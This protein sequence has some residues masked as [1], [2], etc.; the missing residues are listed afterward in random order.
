MTRSLNRLTATA[1]AKAKKPGYFADGG[2]LYLQITAIGAKSWV[3]RYERD[4]R[5]R[6]MGLG[7]VRDFSLAE[8]RERAKVARKQLA[9]GID[10]LAARDEERQ[11]RKAAAAGMMTFRAAAEA[12]IADKAA[13]WRNA[14]HAK[15]WAA[16]LETYAYPVIGDMDVS[17]V[18][19]S[20]VLAILR[21]IWTTKAE[22]ASRVR[23][24]IATV[25]AW[26]KVAGARGGE[27]PAR[28]DDHLD[29]ILAKRSKVA[30]VVHHAALP[31]VDVPAFMAELRA[32]PGVSARAL[33]FVILNANRTGEGLG[34]VDPEFDLAEA[35]WTIPGTRMK[36][37][38]EHVVPLSWRAVQIV[39]EMQATRK[40]GPYIFP[41]AKGGALSNMALLMTLRRMGRD[42]ITAHGFRSSFKDW[43]IEQTNFQGEVSEMALAHRIEDKAEAAYRRGALLTKRRKLMEAWASYCGTPAQGRSQ[44]I[45]LRQA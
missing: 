45:P 44:V 33:E 35:L 39:R 6:E 22:T 8:A 43:A 1:V 2:G 29:Q 7:T 12:C 3:F 37:G 27:N 38:V 42:D 20:H 40:A 30:A 18:D 11:A 41:G 5:R 34:A 24:R 17:R 13:G 21:P 9:D 28:W 4:R 23:G 10:P 25:L 36:A 16:T 26:A 15:Q 32:Q 19:T 31:Y 14:K